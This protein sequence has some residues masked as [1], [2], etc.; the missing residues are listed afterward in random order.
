VISQECEGAHIA[1]DMRGH[2][3]AKARRL[4]RTRTGIL[5]RYPAGACL[6]RGECGKVAATLSCG[7]FADGN[8]IVPAG[9]G[10]DHGYGR[11]NH[12]GRNVPGTVRA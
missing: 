5:C 8:G 10:H 12:R 9:G 3:S 4:C 2:L 6:Y 1:A 11:R 7:A